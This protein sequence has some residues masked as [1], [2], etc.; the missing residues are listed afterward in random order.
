[1]TRTRLHKIPLTVALGLKILIWPTHSHPPKLVVRQDLTVVLADALKPDR[2]HFCKN[3]TPP[4]RA[5]VKHE[6]LVA[7][8]TEHQRINGIILLP[9]GNYFSIESSSHLSNIH[10]PL[11]RDR[12]NWAETKTTRLHSWKAVSTLSG[13]MSLATQTRREKFLVVFA[14]PRILFHHV[15]L[16]W[17]GRL[18]LGFA[19]FVSSTLMKWT[20]SD[21]S[22]QFL[23]LFS[24]VQHNYWN[25]LFLSVAGFVFILTFI[26]WM[27][28]LCR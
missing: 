2:I 17:R 20:V 5:S 4:L 8:L 23:P 12:A 19:N 22:K 11:G 28:V 18:L 3:W 21:E 25:K 1:M 7:R 9:S 13:Q 16:L 26:D 6:P 24:N 14:H 15:W 27:S 10:F